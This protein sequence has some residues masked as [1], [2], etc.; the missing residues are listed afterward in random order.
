[1]STII[2]IGFLAQ[3]LTTLMTSKGL[4]LEVTL[5]TAILILAQVQWITN[6][7]SYV[8]RR[9]QGFGYLIWGPDLIDG[10]YRKVTMH[11]DQVISPKHNTWQAHGK[12]FKISTPANDHLLVTSLDLI[13]ELVEAPRQRLSLHAV[14]K[15]I[16][17]PKYTMHGFEW[18]DRRGVEGTGFV[19]ALRSLLTSHLQ[20]FQPDLERLVRDC[21][22]MEFRNIRSDG[23]AHVALFPVMKR[24]V[25]KVNCFVFF[26]EELSQN[27]EFTAAALEF[28]QDVI[29]AAEF[30]SIT[31]SFM[32]PLVA[33]IATNRHRA[34]KTLYQHLVP[35]V[36]QRLAA[37]DLQ[38]HRI[39]PMDCMQW[40]IDTSPRKN[41]WT[42]ARMVGEIMAVWFGSVHQL[43]MTP[44][45]AI[46]HLCSHPERSVYYMHVYL[47]SYKT[48]DHVMALLVTCR[49]KALSSYTFHDGSTL[50]K[51]DWVC[52]PQQ[53]MLQDGTRYKDAHIFDGFR[54]ARANAQL[55]QLQQLQPCAEVPDQKASRLTHVSPDWPIW[56]LG[57]M[58]W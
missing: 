12:P 26:G 35:I 20:D 28:P 6:A 17:Q 18:Q 23:F 22:E 21:L 44:T 15:E 32:R 58:S 29:F 52:I 2:Q 47:V 55:Q 41:P 4:V 9:I 8:I 33:S 34:A 43:A 40:L 51:G 36:E 7:I 5:L 57:N 45:Y 38:P 49:R 54:F 37:R 50:S 16:L 13:M 48:T 10:A 56:G 27:A 42:P 53:A 25:T 14:A 19:R 3:K 11:Q 24:L 31:P 46:Q 39:T 1:M 30:L